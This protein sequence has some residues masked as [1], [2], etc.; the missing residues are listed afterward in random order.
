MKMPGVRPAVVLGDEVR[1]ALRDGSPIVALESTIISHGMPYPRNV[2]TARRV[3]QIIRDC[4]ATPATIAVLG[5]TPR[6]GLDDAQI[7]HLATSGEI[8]KV[9]T[10]DLPIV[11]AMKRDGATTVA[12][13]MRIASMAGISVFATG[14]TGGVH[15]GGAQ[16][17]D[18]SADL[19]ELAHT[20]VAVVSAGV[21][22]ILDIGLT[23]E[24]LETLGVPVIA[25][26]T[27]VF[28]AFYSRESG[29]DAPL[30]LDSPHDIAAVMR[31]KRELGMDG[32]IL[33]ANPIPH[34]AEIPRAEM[35]PIINDAIGRD[36]IAR[37][38]RQ[39][40]DAIPARAHSRDDQRTQSRGKHRT[41]R[42]QRAARRGDRS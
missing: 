9:S 27:R 12:A 15:R 5:G 39:R 41:R 33:I 2:E 20:N 37:D 35:E 1:Q 32:G 18:V 17:L 16:S 31:A 38:R 28:P 4:G 24:T 42:E 30:S 23:L 25:Y 3:E 14:G 36:G 19:V 22:S 11:V 8:A 6:A 7:E 34:D 21:K 29:F 13:T 10:R 40:R 26:G